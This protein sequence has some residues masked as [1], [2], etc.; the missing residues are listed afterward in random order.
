MTQRRE[1]KSI[2][3]MT[4]EE[5]VFR[6]KQQRERDRMTTIHMRS[7]CNMLRKRR[8]HPGLLQEA[9]RKLGIERVNRKVGPYRSIEGRL[10]IIYTVWK[11]RPLP[12]AALRI[13][14]KPPKRKRI[15]ERL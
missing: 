5:L 10:L 6:N 2:E 1:R 11:K 12:S 8:F 4:L 9:E 15:R 3:R 14:F 13:E 7:V